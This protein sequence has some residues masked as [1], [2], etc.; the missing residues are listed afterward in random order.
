[1]LYEYIF[2]SNPYNIFWFCG[3]VSF[4]FAIGFYIKNINFIKTLI[5]IGFIFQIIWIFDFLSKLLFGSFIIGVTDYMFTDLA[6]LAYLTSLLG[7][8][9]STV[10]ALILTYKYK[11]KKNILIYSFIYLIIILILT[12]SFTSKSDNYN[13]TSHMVIFG[14]FT[15]P[16]YSFIW[17]ILGMLFIVIPT[18]YFQIFLYKYFKK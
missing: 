4:L 3:H 13:L 12:I 18:Y 1:M 5:S 2:I 17:P 10:L 8:F 11:P 14:E 15:F 9:F 7:H 16:G 6:L